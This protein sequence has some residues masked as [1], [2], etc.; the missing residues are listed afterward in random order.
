MSS[1]RTK[2]ICLWMT[3]YIYIYIY[4][5]IKNSAIQFCQKSKS[6]HHQ[7]LVLHDSRSTQL[8]NCRLTHLVYNILINCWDIWNWAQNKYKLATYVSRRVAIVHHET[9]ILVG[10]ESEKWERKT[11]EEQENFLKPNFA[12]EI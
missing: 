10:C 6:K 4:I 8:P 12:T 7:N 5:Y 11:S 9:G 1:D 3:I 2:Q